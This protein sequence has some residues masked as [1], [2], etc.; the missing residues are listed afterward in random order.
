MRGCAGF[1]AIV[2]ASVFAAASALS[3]PFNNAGSVARIPMVPS[4]DRAWK[5]GDDGGRMRK[6]LSYGIFLFCWGSLWVSRQRCYTPC[7]TVHGKKRLGS[8]SMLDDFTSRSDL[9][10]RH[11]SKPPVPT[12]VYPPVLISASSPVQPYNPER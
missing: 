4:S 6:S 1:V 9:C 5:R 10:H 2:L 11:A 7:Q 3:N 12:L 8:Y